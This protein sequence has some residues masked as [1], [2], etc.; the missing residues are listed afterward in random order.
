MHSHVYFNAR[1]FSELFSF[2]EEEFF[3]TCREQIDPR[4]ILPVAMKVLL[5]LEKN[6]AIS[7]L[8]QEQ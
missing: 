2:K 7:Q 6:L 1:I 4:L 3:I 5:N 8:R